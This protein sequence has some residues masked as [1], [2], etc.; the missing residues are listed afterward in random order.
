MIELK[1]EPYCHNCNEFEPTINKYDTAALGSHS[2]FTYYVRC[3]HRKRCRSMVEQL[4]GE[5]ENANR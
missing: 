3:V 2:T 5:L 1:V 4:K